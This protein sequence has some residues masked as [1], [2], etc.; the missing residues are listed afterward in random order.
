[1]AKAKEAT[2]DDAILKSLKMEV[3]LLR[4]ELS[5]LR[6]M[7]EGV[8]SALSGAQKAYAAVAQRADLLDKRMEMTLLQ[9][10]LPR[11]SK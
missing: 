2:G 5:G 11:G 10:K 9:Q 4:E 1:M 3:H 7:L 6:E 8:T